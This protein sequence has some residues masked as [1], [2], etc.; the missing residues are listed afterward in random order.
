MGGNITGELILGALVA[1][2]LAFYLLDALFK[3]EE[4]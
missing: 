4:L 2:A 1:L 3:A